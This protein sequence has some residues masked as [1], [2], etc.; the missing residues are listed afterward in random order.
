[1][2]YHTPPVSLPALLVTLFLGVLFAPALLA[3]P[4]GIPAGPQALAAVETTIGMRVRIEELP[5]PG[6]QL[7]AR[8]VQDPQTAN[9]IL[10]VS[11]I[12]SS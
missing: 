5:L 10:R 7:R 2:T 1:M 8:P 12:N 4:S 9:L 6:S 11:E 3:Q